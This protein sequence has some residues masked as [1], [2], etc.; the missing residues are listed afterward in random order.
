VI[1]DRRGG[2]KILKMLLRKSLEEQDSPDINELANQ[3]IGEFSAFDGPKNVLRL[4][5]RYHNHSKP[6]TS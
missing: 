2:V 4:H 3:R 5:D 1:E 6:V